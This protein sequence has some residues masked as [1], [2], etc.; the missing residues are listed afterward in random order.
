MLCPIFGLHRGGLDDA[1]R[2]REALRGLKNCKGL[3]DLYLRRPVGNSVRFTSAFAEAAMDTVAEG[4]A[5]RVKVYSMSS[6]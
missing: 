2:I 1:L 5:G 6:V 3:R 4:L